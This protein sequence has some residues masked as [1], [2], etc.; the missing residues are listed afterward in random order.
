MQPLPDNSITR[1]GRSQ[2]NIPLGRALRLAALCLALWA[3]LLFP[4]LVFAEKTTWHRVD[5]G[6]EA[7]LELYFFWSKSC[8]HCLSA[9]P[10]VEWMDSAYPWLVVHSLEV[11]DNLGNREKFLAMAKELGQESP[12]VPAFMYCGKV[13]FGFRSDDTTGKL[14]REELQA[15]KEAVEAGGRLPQ[16]AAGEAPMVL[17]LVGEVDPG[18]FSLPVL[19][20]ILAGVDAFNP[21]AFFI[22]LFL[23]SLLVHAQSRA[24]MLLVGGIF[25]LTSGVVYFAFMAAWLNVF[26]AFGEIRSVTRVAGAFAMLL[27]IVNIKDYFF[28]KRGVTLSIPEGAKPGLY[29][30][31]T[32]LI[33]AERLPTLVA[34]TLLLAIAANTYELLCTV[35]F[36][37]LF[38]RVLT[39]KAL[40]T[41]TYYLYLVFYN[42]IYVLPLLA[43]VGVFTLTLGSRKLTET[44]GRLLKLLSGLMMLGL[45]LLLAVAPERLDHLLTALTLPLGAVGLTFL[46][47]FL[48]RARF[49]A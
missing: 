26:L 16:E 7:E 24:R 23:L 14:L 40:P 46:I 17:P 27:A 5:G 35:G 43:I 2:I 11:S 49:R 45:G 47:H 10:L 9:Q 41:G 30:R 42:V 33:R 44:E 6:G 31:I 8:P 12:A 20:V 48:S 38:T 25:I 39:L 13:H 18:R 15:C 19:T 29:Q 1:R 36:P 22:L 3:C 21:C 32:G 28:F 34:G 4:P 37:M